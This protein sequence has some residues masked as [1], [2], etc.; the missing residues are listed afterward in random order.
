MSNEQDWD[1]LAAEGCPYSRLLLLVR[2]QRRKLPEMSLSQA[3]EAGDEIHKAYKEVKE[4]GFIGVLLDEMR[5]FILEVDR[6]T[7]F[8]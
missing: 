6:Y 8:H 4:R 1:K 7:E 5:D 2:D 3:L